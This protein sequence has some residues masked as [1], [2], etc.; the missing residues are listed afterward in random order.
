MIASETDIIEW[1]ESYDRGYLQQLYNQE[2]YSFGEKW[3]KSSGDFAADLYGDYPYFRSIKIRQLQIG[4]SRRILN[5]AVLS[6]SR[7]LGGEPEPE[8]PQVDKW[9]GEW[10]KQVM[11]ERA[12]M[13]NWNVQREN[14][15]TYGDNLG[16]CVGQMYFRDHPVSGKPYLRMRHVPTHNCIWD[17]HCNSLGEADKISFVHYPSPAKALAMYPELKNLPGLVEDDVFGRAEDNLVGRPFQFIRLTEGYWLDG[18]G[19]DPT[20]YVIAGSWKGPKHMIV[21][22]PSMCLDY[23]PITWYEYLNVPGIDRPVGKVTLQQATQEALNEIEGRCRHI[24][25]KHVGFDIAYLHL[26]EP[27]DVDK[28]RRGE[29]DVIVRFKENA[30]LPPG[31]TNPWF[32][33]PAGELSAAIITWW[34]ICNQQYN[35]DSFTTEMDRQQGGAGKTATENV[36]LD[37]RAQQAQTLSKMQILRMDQRTFEVAGKMMA[38]GDQHPTQIDAQGYNVTLNDPRYPETSFASLF[39]EPSRV[40]VDRQ[41]IEASDAAAKQSM[42]LAQLDSLAPEVAAGVISPVWMATEKLKA[43]GEKDPKSALAP[44]AGGD[45]AMGGEPMPGLGPVQGSGLGAQGAVGTDQPLPSGAMQNVQQAAG[46]T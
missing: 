5:N 34:Q 15:F 45:T 10:R 46:V 37:S 11:L 43:I 29:P 19:T 23:L 31:I 42:R 26:L 27:A 16:W 41:S 22:K 2:L 44:A 35:G 4:Q 14:M 3:R 28:I 17:R 38:L 33:V 7:L 25:K 24:V 13:G 8:Y 9:T 18:D 30:V 40:L 12:R 36:L 1:L 21:R 6:V 20:Y 32:R 39:A